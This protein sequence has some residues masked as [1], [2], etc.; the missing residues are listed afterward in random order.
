MEPMTVNI[1]FGQGMCIDAEIGEWTVRTDQPEKEGGTDTGPN[2]FQLFVC[3]LATCAGVY[4]RRFC[5]SRGLSEKG[6]SLS[7][8]CEFH[9]E[10]F[11]VVKIIYDLTPPEGF[12][13][14]YRSALVRSVDLCTVKKHL[15]TPPEFEIRLAD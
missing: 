1:T 13:E 4:A 15:A 8:R 7:M 6:L 14:K 2:P 3:S 5:Q 10:K 12:P 9:H 11:H